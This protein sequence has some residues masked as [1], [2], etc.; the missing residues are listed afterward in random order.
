MNKLINNPKE[1]IF[2]FNDL[3][4][5]DTNS[6]SPALF[7][8]RDGVII[9]DVGYISNPDDVILEPGVENLLR[10]YFEIGIPVI[11]IT[12]QSGISRGYYKWD[13]FE[14]INKK[15][16]ELI[17]TNNPIIAIYANS[18][19]E[20]DE[21][22][23]RKPNPSM[24]L[25][26]SQK[27]NLN[28]NKSIFVGDRLSDMLAGCRSGIKTLIH[29]KTGHGY[30]EYKNILKFCNEDYFCFKDKNSRIFFREDLLQFPYEI[31]N[32]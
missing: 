26:A 31:L 28:I 12:N 30:G 1:L 25:S 16:F 6:L 4:F 29:L 3:S 20:D 18:H 27:Y 9:K 11:V 24:I 17:G 22:N 15:M 21:N 2:E 5:R 19:I 23:W 13:D 14:K 7:L 32:L 10:R 8:D